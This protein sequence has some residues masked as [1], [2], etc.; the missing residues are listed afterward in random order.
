MKI[1]TD[2]SRIIFPVAAAKSKQWVLIVV[3][4]LPDPGV[5]PGPPTADLIH[6]DSAGG[7]YDPSEN[8]DKQVIE[9]MKKVK[10]PKTFSCLP[11]TVHLSHQQ[12]ATDSG[13]AVIMNVLAL[14]HGLEPNTDL[15][16]VGCW[17]KRERYA[18]ACL[19]SAKENAKALA[20]SEEIMK[21]DEK[22]VKPSNRKSVHFEEN[23]AEDP[24]DVC[25]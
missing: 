16:E 9:Y 5:L 25:L 14:I 23:P 6:Y 17:E 11:I 10:K 22:A 19:E 7:Q 20:R 3:N 8:I 18:R 4:M 1:Y 24:E 13:I 21:G 15:N 12:N 2:E